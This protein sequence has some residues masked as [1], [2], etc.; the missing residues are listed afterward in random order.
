MQLKTE[1]VIAYCL[2]II[3]FVVGVVCFAAFRYEGPEEPVRIMLKSTAG[4]VLFDHKEH[5]SEDGYGLECTDCHHMWE[6][7]EAKPDA[8]GEC[9]EVDSEDPINRLDAFHIQCIG[10]HEDDGT[11]PAE[12]ECDKC[13]VFK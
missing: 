12:E 13:H 4:N 10:C 5:T 7:G 3:L 11:A 8:C 1:R 9:H 6:E 2:A